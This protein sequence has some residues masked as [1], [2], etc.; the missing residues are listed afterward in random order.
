M[1]RAE[2]ILIAGLLSAFCMR[3][4]P[5]SLILQVAFVGAVGFSI[6]NW[7]LWRAH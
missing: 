5:D 1:S 2:T 6:V 4:Y 3:R 7:M